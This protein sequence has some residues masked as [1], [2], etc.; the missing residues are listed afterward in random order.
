[1]AVVAVSVARLMPRYIAKIDVMDPLLEGNIP[2]KFKGF[3]RSGR[4][5]VQFIERHKAGEVQGI[6]RPQLL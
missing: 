1:M 6:I 4:Q 5:P 3:H 2:E